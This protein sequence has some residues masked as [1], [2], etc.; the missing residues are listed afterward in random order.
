MCVHIAINNQTVIL[1][2]CLKFT[3]DVELLCRDAS[4]KSL[5]V[6]LLTVSARFVSSRPL[7]GEALITAANKNV[8]A[9]VKQSTGQK[10]RLPFEEGHR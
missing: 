2:L 4:I 6:L 3:E 8:T 7:V 5:F 9:F 10:V 1:F